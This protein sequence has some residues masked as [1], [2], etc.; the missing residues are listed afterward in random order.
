MRVVVLHD[1]LPE[2]AGKDLEDNLAQA[3]EVMRALA[4][5]GH[6]ASRL[7]LVDPVAATER[8]LR[9]L[10]PEVVFNL[11]EAP[12]GRG[13]LIPRAPR[14][15]ERLRLPFT[16]AGTAAMRATSQKLAAKRR[17]RRA[18]LP[19][20]DWWHPGEPSPGLPPGTSY[21]LKSVWEHGSMGL[22]EHSL[23][24]GFDPRE[25]GAQLA[26]ARHRLGGDGFAEEYV[27][28]REFNLSLLAGAGGVA[29]L[30]PAEI[31]FE[32]FASHGRPAIV[33]YRAKWQ[34]ESYEYRHTPRRFDLPA[35]DAGLVAELSRLA[36]ACWRLFGLRGWARVDFR[37]TPAGAPFILEVNANPC[38]AA[39]AGF[40]AAAQRA[41]LAPPAVVARILADAHCPGEV[42]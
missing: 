37:V 22:D 29:L 40:M 17:L 33:G 26:V 39:E 14:L 21:L 9:R 41:G 36:L 23:R 20:P 16:G 42:G 38:L 30:P 24:Q 5:L 19:T 15:L 8:E 3:G 35:A 27:A 28:G 31:L 11:V 18:G 2:G 6:D 1:A 4:V 32:D 25:A 13:C 34:A 7:A 10:H 12:L